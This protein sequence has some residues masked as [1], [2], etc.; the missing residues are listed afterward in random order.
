MSETVRR[1]KRLKTSKEKDS[2]AIA[3]DIDLEALQELK[4]SLFCSVCKKFPRPNVY[5]CH[6]CDNIVCS[7]CW[8]ET[9]GWFDLKNEPD[10]AKKL[11]CKNCIQKC[12]DGEYDCLNSIGNFGISHALHLQ[13]I[14]NN[15]AVNMGLCLVTSTRIVGVMEPERETKISVWLI[16]SFQRWSRYSSS[17]HVSFRRMDAKTN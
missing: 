14:P 17:I 15:M 8:N 2:Q 1:S 4:K 13:R 5:T 7:Y 10:L 6:I 11:F 16:Q 9:E 3:E 12:G